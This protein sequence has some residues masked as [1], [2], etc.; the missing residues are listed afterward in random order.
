M[1]PD[2]PRERNLRQV[3]MG[4]CT[5][6]AAVLI[7][8]EALESIRTGIPVPMGA[9]GSKPLDGWIV[10]PMAGFLAFLGFCVIGVGLGYVKLKRPG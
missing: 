4:I 2:A 7:G 1:T 8:R 10:L 6:A 9:G 3:I 5:V